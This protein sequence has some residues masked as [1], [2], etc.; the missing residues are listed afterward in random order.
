MRCY[1]S[2][3][4]TRRNLAALM[5]HG[6]GLCVSSSA[7]D[8][9]RPGWPY[10]LDNGAWTAFQQGT[11]WDEVAFVAAVERYGAGAD[12]V[13]APDVVGGG[14]ASLDLSA[15]WL[16]WLLPRCRRIVIGVQEGMAPA[17]VAPLRH[18][19]VGVG[20]GGA[21]RKWKEA[22]LA[23]RQWVGPGPLHVF[24]NANSERQIAMA[25]IYGA[26]SVDGTN[27]T[28]HAITT[29]RLARAMPQEPIPWPA[30]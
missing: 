3:T 12:F 5:R 13:V 16:P 4:R 24:R 8:G 27:A 10:M 9:Y 15:S 21:T 18:C 29:K 17:D 7:I 25:R 23:S 11:P 14:M 2:A 20:I 26:T 22:Q 6:W 1:A 30:S 28:R 19:R